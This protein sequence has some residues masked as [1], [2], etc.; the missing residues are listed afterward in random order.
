M[1]RV[2]E[3]RKWEI[4]REWYCRTEEKAKEI[5]RTLIH[6]DYKLNFDVYDEIFEQENWSLDEFIEWVWEEKNFD[7]VLRVFEIEFEEDKEN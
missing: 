1:F 7:D 3:F 2:V 4:V 6:K 5:V